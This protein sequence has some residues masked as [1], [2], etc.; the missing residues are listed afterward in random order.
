[1]IYGIVNGQK[2]RAAIP[3]PRRA[4]C[5]GCG[6]VLIAKTG[7]EVVWHWA[8]APGARECD[9]WYEPAEMTEWHKAWQ[10]HL[11][12]G[13][14]S[15]AEVTL[16]QDGVIHR[17]DVILPDGT[18]VEI[19]HSS[20]SSLRIREREEFY[21]AHAPMV[22]LVDE[23]GYS[24]S[25]TGLV[26]IVSGLPADDEEVTLRHGEWRCPWDDAVDSD[27]IPKMLPH[28]EATKAAYILRLEAERQARLLAQ[29]A[30]AERQAAVR[31]AEDEADREARVLQRAAQREKLRADP[32]YQCLA[33]VLPREAAVSMLR[34]YGR[35]GYLSA[36]QYAWVEREAR[37]RNYDMPY[38]LHIADY[39]TP[40][41]APQTNQQPVVYGFGIPDPDAENLASRNRY[42]GWMPPRGCV[43]TVEDLE[44][45][46]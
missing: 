3:G 6:A 43:R 7:T 5:E 46:E 35:R 19:Q 28:F 11:S 39:P 17:A 37:R 14:P 18:I 25:M 12:G 38:I 27:S 22:W 26:I 24:R 36:K 33:A 31:R 23:A 9:S 34:M 29:Q 20:L 4:T 42:D 8:H 30:E 21:R 1:M 2:V 10:E 16:T 44:D 41:P 15:R 45:D 32:V 13:D 40:K